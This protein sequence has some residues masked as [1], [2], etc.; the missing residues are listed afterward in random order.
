MNFRILYKKVKNKVVK[1]KNHLIEKNAPIYWKRLNELRYW[2]NRKNIEGVL[3][4]CHYRHFYTKHFGINVDY[5][6]NKTILD[7]G[8]GPRGSLEWASNSK[9]RIGLD[10]LAKEYLKLGA[11]D[12]KMEYF[13]SASEK[14]PLENNSCDAVFSFNSLDH[15]E[16]VE[17]TIQEIKRIVRCNGIFLLLVE[18]NHLP[19]ACEPHQLN[20]KQI[21]KLLKPEFVCED[22]KVFKPELKGMYQSILENTIISNPLETGEVGYLSA[23]FIKQ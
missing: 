2:N 21:L 8:C 14:I 17:R 4:N 1:G 5:F 20:A 11:R 22:L 7:I 19:T 10:P 12:H 18:I 3:N 6:E 23:K 9:R 15:V 16:S 13:D